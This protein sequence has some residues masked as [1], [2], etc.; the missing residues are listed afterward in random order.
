MSGKK[1][2]FSLLI[3]WI[4]L[5]GIG[6]FFIFY[7][8][9]EGNRYPPEIVGTSRM[10]DAMFGIYAIGIVFLI[11]SVILYFVWQSYWKNQAL[12]DNK[13]TTQEKTVPHSLFDSSFPLSLHGNILRINRGFSIDTVDISTV[14]WIHSH[15]MYSRYGGTSLM[16]YFYDSNGK[17]T[18]ALIS[19]YNIPATLDIIERIIASKPNIM[20][21]KGLMSAEYRR[22]KRLYKN[23]L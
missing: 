16:L 5:W 23:R 6:A 11:L 18:T 22:Y 7:L 13:L 14:V 15:K 17:K 10:R 3:V 8:Y 9:T 12:Y 21:S 20:N 2:I 19:S 4:I 1:K